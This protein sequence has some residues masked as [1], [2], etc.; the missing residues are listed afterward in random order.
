MSHLARVVAAA[1]VLLMANAISGAQ[2]PPAAQ[3]AGTV[4]EGKSGEP[5]SGV[6]VAIAGR[7]LPQR[8]VVADLRGR[9]VF[10]NLPPGVF[11]VQATTPGYLGGGAGQLQPMSLP[12]PLELTAGARVTDLTLR[13]WKLGVVEGTIAGDANE[14]LTSVEVHALRRTLIGG[15]WR[16]ADTASAT[17]DD[18]GR[19]RIVSLPPGDYMIAARPPRIRDVALLLATLSANPANASDIIIGATMSGHGDPEPDARVRDYW[20]AVYSLTSAA[21]PAI[22]PIGVETERSG[23]DFHLKSARGVRVS[24]T[25]TGAGDVV[26]GLTIRLMPAGAPTDLDALPLEAAIAACDHDGHFAFSGVAPGRYVAVVIQ[27]PAPVPPPNPPPVSPMAT[28]SAPPPLPSDPT[29]WAR[30]PITVRTTDVAGVTIQIHKGAM[31]SGR[32]EIDGPVRPLPAELRQMTLR[33]DPVDQPAPAGNAPAWRGQVESDGRFITM[34]VPPGDYLLRV[35]S[36]PRGWTIQSAL[37][38]GRDILDEPITVGDHD[39]ADVTLNLATRPLASMVGTV[40]GADGDGESGA[41]V[42]IFPA[43]RDA[44]RDT[45]PLARRL[46]VTRPGQSGAYAVQALPAGDYFVAAIAGSPAPSWQDPSELAVLAHKSTRVHL[47]P[48]ATQT[49]DVR[50]IK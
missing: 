14:P 9:F 30:L 29:W 43:G 45:G 8:R 10:D 44:W 28:P 24:G 7:G 13:L 41:T 1:A 22:I 39:I 11:S 15:R 21:V 32:V 31:V 36:P 25:A 18:R 35:S 26:G 37:A 6:V 33:L 16:L 38:D 19:Y 3:V 2:A 12:R 27:P 50:V 42:M 49:V 34:S 48:G 20:L 4:V 47:E 23:L 17:T 40:L 46:R 5:I